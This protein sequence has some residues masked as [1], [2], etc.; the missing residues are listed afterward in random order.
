MKHLQ[1]L[2][3]G[4]NIR[5][6]GCGEDFGKDRENSKQF[7]CG[8]CGDTVY[9]PG[10]EDEE[11]EEEFGGERE[12]N[13]GSMDDYDIA[14]DMIN[15]AVEKHNAMDE[16][17]KIADVD[18]LVDY[19]QSTRH[20]FNERI[21]QNVRDIIADE[22]GSNEEEENV[23]PWRNNKLQNRGMENY[24]SSKKDSNSNYKGKLAKAARMIP[25][26]KEEEEVKRIDIDRIRAETK[27]VLDDSRKRKMARDFGISGPSR[28]SGRVR[29]R[30]TGQ[31]RGTL[32][33]E[34]EEDNIDDT[35][36]QRRRRRRPTRDEGSDTRRSR[37]IDPKRAFARQMARVARPH[38]EQEETKDDW[39]EEVRKFRERNKKHEPNARPSRL[40]RRR[41]RSTS[42]S[43]VF[44]A[45]FESFKHFLENEYID[46]PDCNGGYTK[47][48]KD[49]AKCE[50][51]GKLYEKS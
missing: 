12:D 41:R 23:D 24:Y 45:R 47:D 13:D 20:D 2:L 3:E 26:K 44:A 46:C 16:F 42:D 27:A 6:S 15:Q 29:R 22:T 31:A 39:N 34:Q 7:T 40:R 28:R 49:C 30:G 19:L 5:C 37:R 50:G 11:N 8:N 38:V 10:G 9:N 18:S 25:A 4:M 17:D 32:G 36:N 51:N 21:E 48:G 43:G 1:E 14:I 35:M 33:F